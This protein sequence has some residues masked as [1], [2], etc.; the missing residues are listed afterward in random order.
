MKML[1]YVLAIVFAIVAVMYLLIPGGS[2]PAFLPGYDKGST[3][4]HTMHAIAA[5][6]A[7]FVF[8]LIGFSRW[9]ARRSS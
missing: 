4:I 8:F 1:A 2:L 5:A 3:H 6:T 9:P 7:A